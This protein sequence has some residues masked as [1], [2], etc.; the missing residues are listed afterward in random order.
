VPRFAPLFG[1]VSRHMI[2]P[3]SKIS[4]QRSAVLFWASIS[5]ILLIARW[6]DIAALSL[7]DADDNLRLMQVRAL[8]DGQSWFD[9][10]QY[11]LD[12]AGGADMHWSRLVD[13][14]IAALILLAQPFVGIVAAEKFA[15]ALAPLLPFLVV[16]MG[17]ARMARA[18][19]GAQA[20][21]AAFAFLLLSS[22]TLSAFSPTRVDHHGW[23]LAAVA[24]LASAIMD[25]NVVRGGWT[26]GIAFAFSLSI[27]VEMLPFLIAGGGA[28]VMLWVFDSAQAARLRS[29]A[30]GLGGGSALSYLLFVSESNS[31]A[32]CDA[33]SPV[34]ASVAL[35]AAALV[36]GLSH[37]K[38]DVM[39]QRLLFATG[40]GIILISFYALAWPTCLSRFEGT[41]PELQRMWLDNI[42]EAQPIY[43]KSWPLLLTIGSMPFFGLASYAWLIRKNW[44]DKAALQRIL[45]LALLAFSATI[46]LLFQT[47]LILAAQLLAVP[48]IAAVSLSALRF[49]RQSE[50]ML[51]RVFGTALVFFGPTGL[52]ISPLASLAPSPALA[53]A[54]VK[55]GA[56]GAA[57]DLPKHFVPLAALPKTTVLTFL[58][59]GP[60]LIVHTH[61]DAIAG[62]YHRTG[63]AILNVMHAFRGDDAR[64]LESIRHHKAGL[65]L[66]CPG[67]SE[68]D[69]Y[70]NSKTSFYA[71]LAAGKAPGWLSPVSL[72]DGSPYKAWRVDPAVLE[73]DEIS[74][75]RNRIPEPVE[76]LPLVR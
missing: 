67:M 42:T 34:W 5:V 22:F 66:I 56:D 75:N 38:R 17:V 53:Q 65:V 73:S 8:L 19:G 35:L 39:S 41:S 18:V 24:V 68:A 45:P 9:L 32:R 54:V 27:G 16:T 21:W 23:Q 71:R 6:P 37:I 72:G 2:E 40:A 7:S 57:C 63:T 20:H 50:L 58:S 28:I 43:A 49:T 52:L 4:W 1:M 11:R 74:S 10:R 3:M 25:R 47:R 13:L 33:M 55:E 70:L 69:H 76:G 64:A 59:T 44:G 48:G 12:P 26:A 14:P 29:F 62:P 60:K 46:L 36:F 30:L 31:L 15:V 51:V 61:H